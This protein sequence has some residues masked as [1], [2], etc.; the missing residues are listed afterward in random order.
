MPLSIKLKVLDVCVVSSLTYGC[1]SW[2]TASIN[3]IE[4]TYRL[5][6]KRALSI[7]ETV[8]TEIVYI[9]ANRAPLNISIAKQQLNFWIG[10]QSYL[11]NN[12]EHPLKG[13]IEQGLASNLQYLRY[14]NDLQATYISPKNLEDVLTNE[15]RASTATKINAKSNNDA[16]SRLGVY[17]QVNPNL[18]PPVQR[19][20][21]LE[22][23]RVLVTRYR[24]GSH[25]LKIEAGHLCNPKI[26]RED[27]ICKCNLGIQ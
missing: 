19:N 25:N 24:C 18:T 17:L 11:D 13:L 15:F 4:V 7:R 14:Y 23:E 2:A 12:P 3:S 21:I 1:E 8:N 10:L 26:P 22:F 5:G 6:L 9:E 20:N 27:R 16:E